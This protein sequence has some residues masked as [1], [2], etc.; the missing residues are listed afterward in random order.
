M[1]SLFT[2]ILLVIAGHFIGKNIQDR[3]WIL[4]KQVE[5]NEKEF[6]AFKSLITEISQLIS[7]RIYWTKMRIES[8][9]DNSVQEDDKAIRD[10]YIDIK[11]KWNEKLNFFYFSFQVYNCHELKIDLQDLQ[12]NFHN[13]HYEIK[14]YI[15]KT[16]VDNKK[17]TEYSINKLNTKT[18]DFLEKINKEMSDRQ[19]SFYQKNKRTVSIKDL[20]NLSFFSLIKLLFDSSSAHPSI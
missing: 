6:N 10:N 18:Y 14:N 13:L 1:I 17:I 12:K 5:D 4:K 19:N 11:D 9:R 20:N 2:G 7:T 15:K 16:T 8:I 3:S